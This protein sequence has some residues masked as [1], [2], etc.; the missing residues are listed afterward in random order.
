MQNM[1]PVDE[2]S[3][4]DH[5]EGRKHCGLHNKVLKAILIYVILSSTL[6]YMFAHN[7]K[8]DLQA[9]IHITFIMSAC[10]VMCIQLQRVRILNNS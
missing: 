5:T 9:Q 2:N 7:H 4:T 10:R 8:T 3:N 1:D 6:W